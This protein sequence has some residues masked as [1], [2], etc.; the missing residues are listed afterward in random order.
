MLG[1]AI[2][3][4]KINLEKIHIFAGKILLLSLL[5]LNPF[6]LEQFSPDK[7]LDQINL[8]RILVLDCFLLVTGTST[9]MFTSSTMPR[10]YKIIHKWLTLFSAYILIL[11]FY[12]LTVA[13]YLENVMKFVFLLLLIN[14]LINVSKYRTRKIISILILELFIII[15]T[16]ELISFILLEIERPHRIQLELHDEISDR[17]VQNKKMFGNGTII[18]NVT[19]TYDELGRRCSGENSGEKHLILFGGSYT[20]GHGLEDNK[21]LP[22]YLSE[23]T[24]YTVYNYAGNGYG[25]QQM[26]GHLEREEFPDE[27]PERDGKAIYVFIYHHIYRIR[28]D[29]YL[30]SAGKW[31]DRVPYY[32][33]DENDE[34]K[35]RGTI[36]SEQPFL[37][38]LFD[39]IYSSNTFKYLYYPEFP[40]FAWNYNESRYLTFRIIKKSKEIYESKFNGTFYVVFHPSQT[41]SLLDEMELAENGDLNTFYGLLTENGI[42]ILYYPIGYSE[43]DKIPYDGHPTGEFNERFAKAVADDLETLENE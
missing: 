42:P 1:R 25:P 40:S 20:F 6:V 10:K 43:K 37:V 18:F 31:A 28:G 29:A 41:G 35:R 7:D 12:D 21:T 30:F 36:K 9:L 34:L 39:L 16:L 15:L 22:F 19:Y 26:L 32:Y 14:S 27:F 5:I 2:S 4:P 17:S 13:S 3:M 24:N 38:F 33:L 8:A 23:F 11:F